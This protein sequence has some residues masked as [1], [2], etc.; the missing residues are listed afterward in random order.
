MRRAFT[1][2]AL[3]FLT[4]CAASVAPY[5]KPYQG[6]SEWERRYLVEAKRD[7]YPSDV[8]RAPET[9]QQATLAWPGIVLSVRPESQ[10]PSFSEVVIEHHYWDWIEDHSIQ[11]AKAFL[12]PR[13]EGPFT[14]HTEKRTLPS[15]ELKDA[16]AV[17]YVRPVGVKDDVLHAA[18][19]I[20]FY[21]REWYA[22]DVMD[23]GRNGEGIKMLRVPME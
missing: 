7:V 2:V 18:C 21:P 13:G 6:N 3:V 11:K 23:Y 4:G 22:T 15:V 17:A 12:S 5:S 19:I 9:F 1:A 14:C 20:R 10:D 16:M 8:R